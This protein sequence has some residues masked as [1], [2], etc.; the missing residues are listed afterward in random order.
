MSILSDEEKKAI[1]DILEYTENQYEKSQYGYF[2]MGGWAGYT[3][4][5]L[6]KRDDPEQAAELKQ[7][8]YRVK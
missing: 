1:C 4:F 8:I 5:N 6:L 3:L 2:S 7:K